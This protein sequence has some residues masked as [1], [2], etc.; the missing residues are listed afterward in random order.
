VLSNPEIYRRLASRFIGLRLDWE[1]GNHFKDRFG[2]ILGTGD[3]L[4]LDPDGTPIPHDE[5]GRARHSVRAEPD[6]NGRPNPNTPVRSTLIY[7][8]HGCD[9]TPEILD[10][11]AGQF[12][13]KSSGLNPDWFL[14]PRKPTRRKGGLYP[15][16]HESIAGYARLPL[17]FVEGP[18]PAAIT[19]RVFLERH[20]RQFIWVRGTAEG[21]SRIRIVRVKD[22][23]KQGLSPEIATIAM[24]SDDLKTIDQSLDA[25]WLE[26]MKARPFTARGYIENPHGKWMRRLSEQMISEDE[27]IRRR[28]TAGTLLPP[29][30]LAEAP[31]L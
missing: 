15:V 9:T 27:E 23:L 14:W 21:E 22:G 3:Q 13:L 25:A 31:G 10:Q 7:G 1:Q 17:A 8:R 5:Q 18:M 4:L 24:G 2:F 11:V 20:I 16:P 26:Y 30:R 29:G 19:N 12:P 6:M 28:A